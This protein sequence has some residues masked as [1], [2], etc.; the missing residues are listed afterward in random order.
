MDIEGGELGVSSNQG[1]GGA[2][3]DK[4]HRSVRFAT[5]NVNN[6]NDDENDHRHPPHLAKNP[7]L[8]MAQKGSF[9]SIS[10]PPPT[11]DPR[12]SPSNTSSTAQKGP[13]D[14]R[15][16]SSSS[17]LSLST[18]NEHSTK[19]SAKTE[20]RN[21]TED[22][23]KLYSSSQKQHPFTKIAAMSFRWVGYA[24]LLLATSLIHLFDTP[25]QHP[26]TSSHDTPSHDTPSHTP[27]HTPLVPPLNTLVRELMG[28][29]PTQPVFR[30]LLLPALQY[31]S[32]DGTPNLI[33][34]YPTL[35]PPYPNSILTPT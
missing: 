35:T 24:C 33:Q 1:R 17:S 27:S 29:A 26:H 2:I 4:S 11:L 6:N 23:S 30:S 18:I 25:S 34:P 19:D 8:S 16:L 21:A 5:V 7:M 20:E 28:R 3:V 12:G 31:T 13:K 9:S 14:V 15:M 32:N 22:S 10:L